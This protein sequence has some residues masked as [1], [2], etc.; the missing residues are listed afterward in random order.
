MELSAE[1]LIAISGSVISLLFSYIPGLRTWYAAKS[2]E[3]KR[4]LMLVMVVVVSG[5]IFGLSCGGVI[6]TNIACNKDGIWA[7]VWMV[8]LAI[9]TNQA[10][11]LLTPKPADVRDINAKNALDKIV[12]VG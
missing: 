6:D 3:I 1:V 11:F 7:L 5:A 10:T 2:D 4:L 8:L 9:S 12:S